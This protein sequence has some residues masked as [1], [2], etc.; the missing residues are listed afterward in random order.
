MGTFDY[1]GDTMFFR[2]S[3]DSDIVRIQR[4]TSPGNYGPIVD[5]PIEDLA[6]FMRRVNRSKGLKNLHGEVM[7]ELEREYHE[8]KAWHRLQ[9]KNP[10]GIRSSQISALVMLLI[11]KGVLK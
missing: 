11:K 6:E 10:I 1:I 8:N 5:V 4:K 7:D 9:R 3:I 2:S